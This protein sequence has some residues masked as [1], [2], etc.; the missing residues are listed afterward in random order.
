M[1]KWR[2]RLAMAV[3]LCAIPLWSGAQS[4]LPNGSAELLYGGLLHWD[5]PTV[6]ETVLTDY[7]FPQ[8][9]IRCLKFDYS[10]ANNMTWATALF[11]VEPSATYHFRGYYRI[12][13]ALTSGSVA[14][15][16]RWYRDHKR[17]AGPPASQ[18]TLVSGIG[19]SAANT[20]IIF[21][22][23]VQAP[24]DVIGAD[25]VIMGEAEGPAG[26]IFYD[27]F[28]LDKTSGPYSATI[29]MVHE[30]Y[31][32][33]G[34]GKYWSAS[35]DL[36]NS[37]A[38]MLAQLNTDEYIFL[39]PRETEDDA[40]FRWAL[41]LGTYYGACLDYSYD[42]PSQYWNLINSLKHY[43]PN[44]QFIR[45]SYDTPYSC[46]WAMS[47]GGLDQCLAAEQSIAADALLYAGF[48]EKENLSTGWTEQQVWQRFI[49]NPLANRK[50]MCENYTD[51]PSDYRYYLSDLAICERAWIFW[52]PDRGEPRNT[53]LSWL[54]DDARHCGVSAGDEGDRIAEISIRGKTT[55]PADWAWNL[56]T[57]SRFANKTPR[58]PLRANPLSMRDIQWEDNVC[59][60][61]FRIT[62]GDNLQVLE[63]QWSFD[64][65]WWASPRRG[66]VALGWQLP[67][68]MTRLAP[69]I[70]SS[71]FDPL[72]PIRIKPQEC[73]VTGVS[74]D[75][76]FFVGPPSDTTHSFGVLTSKGTS[77]I[78]D[79]AARLNEWMKK[80]GINIITAFPYS[81]TAWTGYNF[82]NYASALERPLA[83]TVDTYSGAYVDGR[84]EL[85]WTQDK[86]NKNIP[87]KAT[88]Y[89]LW[90][91]PEGKTAPQIAALVNAAPHSGAPTASSFRQI[92]AHAWS[93]MDPPKQGIVE[94]VYQ[95]AS[96]MNSYV[97][98]VRP[99][100]FFMQMRLR[101]QTSQELTG[102]QGTLANK[103][104]L[105]EAM[106]A[107]TTEAASA[108][109]LARQKLNDANP[110]IPANPALAFTYL[111]EGDQQ[112]EI[113]RLSFITLATSDGKVMIS[114]PDEASPLY[115]FT[116]R[117]TDPAA[118]PVRCYQV[119]ASEDPGFANPLIDI[120]VTR[121]SCTSPPGLYVR[122]RA[123]GDA[124]G[125]WG[126][127]SAPLSP[128]SGVGPAW[129]RY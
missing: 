52:D 123:Q 95:S 91:T 46:R 89:A 101:L 9:G 114:C 125:D 80:T 68:S 43:L 50:F 79:H 82:Y 111:K 70:W 2:A 24:P 85:K 93:W 48:S 113:A 90:D 49:A 78:T 110:L 124:H 103:V 3:L 69:V 8:D 75:G 109:T 13:E 10:A 126:C 4:I 77:L 65:R 56:A 76:V 84:G 66:Q 108:R 112:T 92:I 64:P 98:V 128:I 53:Y 60:C 102:Y 28:T 117:E 26:K 45:F 36:L 115:Y 35:T 67:P 17:S 55:I 104:A 127:W 119:Q 47:L 14:V 74:G 81:R 57:L 99:D 44:Q 29:R 37:M 15:N 97:R 40:A 107:P 62:D 42:H 19:P 51:Y 106:P 5:T 12:T 23:D 7:S 71:Y 18:Q 38:G 20:W 63:G 25:V 11:A 22:Q 96:I 100:E 30:E 72:S 39:Y 21:E 122:A 1:K 41:G 120:I 121:P 59:Y 33:R 16:I 105:L 61:A 88:D 94:E 83:L 116:L 32:H 73:F 27:H 129:R 118:L 31:T 54:D 34:S 87:V 6:G 86:K 58:T